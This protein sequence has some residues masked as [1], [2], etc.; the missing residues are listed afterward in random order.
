M[1]IINGSEEKP[2]KFQYDE[3]NLK[4]SEL[5]KGTLKRIEEMIN[6]QNNNRYFLQNKELPSNFGSQ[7]LEN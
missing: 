2:L 7:L 6:Q 5:R 3:A 1:V 4:S